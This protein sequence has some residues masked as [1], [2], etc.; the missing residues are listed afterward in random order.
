M[1]KFNIFIF[2]LLFMF[3]SFATEPQ[4]ILFIHSS[5]ETFRNVFE[6]MKKDLG[7]YT[8]HNYEFN[9]TTFTYKDFEAKVK[10]ENANINILMDNKTVEFALKYNSEH[11]QLKEKMHA[12]ALMSLNLRNI[13]NNDPFIS[14]IAFEIPGYTLFTQFRYILDKPLKNVIV[15][16]RKSIFQSVIDSAKEQ[17]A[18]ENI[19]LEPVDVEQNGKSPKDID[20][21][22]EKNMQKYVNLNNHYDATWVML[23]SGLLTPQL[24]TKYWVPIARESKVP[25]ISSVEN[26]VSEQMNFA[27]FALTPNIQNLSNQAVQMVQNILEGNLSTN[28]AGVEEIISVNKILNMNRI[29]ERNIKIKKENLSEINIVE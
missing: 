15:F 14:G 9:P 19:I 28:D 13:L 12:V 24:F 25:F 10:E 4:K 3:A 27:T 17:L 5:T 18:Q 11:T 6:Y 21:F 16:Y 2:L 29:K 8:I 20:S 23:D 1:N 26:F 22:F 7:K